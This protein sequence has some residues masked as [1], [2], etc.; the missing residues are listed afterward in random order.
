MKYRYRIVVTLLLASLICGRIS[1][2]QELAPYRLTLRDAI[3]R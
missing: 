3:Q 2:A 1:P